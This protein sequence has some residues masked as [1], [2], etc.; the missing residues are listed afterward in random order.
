MIYRSIVK[1]LLDRVGALLLLLLLAPVIIAVALAIRLSM[2]SPLLF[3]Q[4]RPGKGGAIFSIYKFRTM[5]NDKDEH[6]E[7]L[8]DAQR[9]KGVGKVIRA[10][11]LDELP[12]ILNVLRGEMSFVG[13]RPLLVEYLPLYSPTQARRHEVTPGITGWAQVNG[14]NAIS[15]EEKFALDVWY[16]DHQSFALDLR[17]ALLTLKKIFIKEGITQEGHATMSKFE[18]NPLFI[19][20]KSGHGKVVA[21]LARDCGYTLA[22]WIDD[23]QEGA[24]RWES[25]CQEHKTATIAL[26]IGNNAVRARIAHKIKAQGYTLATLIHPSSIIDPS[27]TIGEGSV[28]MPLCVVNADATI[29]QGAI[30]NTQCVVE[31]DCHIAPFAHLSPHSALAGGVRVGEESHIGIGASVIQLIT[32]GDRTTIGAGGVVI[33]NIPSDVTAVGVPA[34]F[35]KGDL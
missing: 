32:I 17:I 7:L 6:G 35:L 11:S 25:F 13:P 20:G 28:V 33:T 14:R 1:P 12:Q 16:V 5:T 10:L 9:L 4:A 3:R 15:W 27:S 30:L 18:G 26:G 22:G 24:W 2:G 29:A 19:Y 8:P 34:K 23:R 31:H 21:S